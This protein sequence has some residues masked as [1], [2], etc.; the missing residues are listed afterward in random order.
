MPRKVIEQVEGFYRIIPLNRFRETEGVSFDYLAPSAVPRI[1]AIDRVIHTSNAVSPGPV[2]DVERPWYMH[3]HQDDNLIV[4]HGERTVDIYTREHSRA[5]R[6][7]VKPDEI[8]RGDTV[9]FTG[10]AMLVW[11]KGVFHRIQS[12]KNGS[13]SLNLATHYEG[14]DL[15]TNFNI[16]SLN[17]ETGK[18]K[19]IREGHLDQH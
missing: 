2:G 7:L 16:Y 17:P 15:K 14:F 18:F 6:F 3:P 8:Y 1:S 5:E 12:G 19:M 11:P 4:L 13:A 9:I 10:P